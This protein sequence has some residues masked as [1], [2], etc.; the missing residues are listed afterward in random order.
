ME[1]HEGSLSMQSYLEL[2]P[3]IEYGVGPATRTFERWH[4]DPDASA[5]HVLELAI[6]GPD[7]SLHGPEEAALE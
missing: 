6:L 4:R 7:V 5:G 1:S 3:G 2:P